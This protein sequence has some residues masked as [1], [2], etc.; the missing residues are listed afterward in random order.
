[1]VVGLDQYVLESLQGEEEYSRRFNREN[2]SMR[3]SSHIERV[4]ASDFSADTRQRNP[5]MDSG[6]YVA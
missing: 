5:Q 1:M 2:C 6:A 3:T 4:R